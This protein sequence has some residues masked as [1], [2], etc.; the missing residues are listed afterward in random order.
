MN[1]IREREE[2]GQNVI[3]YVVDA[4]LVATHRKPGQFVIVRVTGPR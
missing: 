3:R 1:T 4:P 2:L